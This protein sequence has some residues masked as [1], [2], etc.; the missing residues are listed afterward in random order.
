MLLQPQQQVVGYHHQQ[1]QVAGLEAVA[2]GQVTTLGTGQVTSL[3]GGH[4]T[5]LG[6]GQVT[7][8]DALLAA[9]TTIPVNRYTTDYNQNHRQGLLYI[10]FIN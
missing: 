5:S 8:L 1:Q 3:G 6:A 10:I 7:S 9:N 4:I 2:A